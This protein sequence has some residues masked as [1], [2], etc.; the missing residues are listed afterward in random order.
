MALTDEIQQDLVEAF[1][2]DLD[3]IPVSV[4][5]LSHLGE[6]PTYDPRFGNI[7]R[8]PVTTHTFN[9]VIE[10]ELVKTQ[11]NTPVLARDIQLIFPTSYLPVEPYIDDFVKIISDNIYYTI[12]ETLSDPARAHYSLLARP[13]DDTP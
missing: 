8:P 11:F 7:V 6:N 5:Y 2:V 13:V 9:A 10:G 12:I 1:Q 4:E 3:N